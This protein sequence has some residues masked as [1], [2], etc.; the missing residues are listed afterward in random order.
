MVGLDAKTGKEVWGQGVIA[1]LRSAPTVSDGRV[2][3]ITV[4]NQLEVIAASD[5][6]KL[7]SHTGTPESAGLLGGASPAVEGDGVV[8]AYSSGEVLAPGGEHRRQLW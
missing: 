6:R 8:G 1:P 4:D 2:F 3:A 7:W 5:G